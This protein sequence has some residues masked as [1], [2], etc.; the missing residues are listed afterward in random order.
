MSGIELL[1]VAASILQLADIAST[2][3]S[4]TNEL[5]DKSNSARGTIQSIQT[6]C[7]TIQSAVLSIKV[8][9]EATRNERS[10]EVV[11]HVQQLKL[12]VDLLHA[13]LAALS[14]D[15]EAIKNSLRARLRFVLSDQ[16]LKMLLEEV[17]WQSNALHLLLSALH[18][19]GP[20]QNKLKTVANSVSIRYGID[21]EDNRRRVPK[22]GSILSD[23][24]EFDFD[25][26]I[27][28]SRV[29]RDALAA[30]RQ[31]RR[32]P[33]MVPA[34]RPEYSI[35]LIPTEFCVGGPAYTFSDAASSNSALGSDSPVASTSASS[36]S[37]TATPD[38]DCLTQAILDDMFLCGYK[39][40]GQRLRS[41]VSGASSLSSRV[42]HSI[43]IRPNESWESRWRFY[44]YCAPCRWHVDLSLSVCAHCIGFNGLIRVD[45]RLCGGCCDT[46]P[47]VDGVEADGEVQKEKEM[48]EKKTRRMES[49]QK[50]L[51]DV[52]D[53]WRNHKNH[54]RSNFTSLFDGN[55]LQR[56]NILRDMPIRAAKADSDDGESDEDDDAD[57]DADGPLRL[58]DYIAHA[59]DDQ[60]VAAILVFSCAKDIGAL[61]DTDKVVKT[62]M[63]KMHVKAVQ[64]KLIY[65]LD[66]DVGKDGWVLDVFG[67]L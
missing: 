20:Q 5:K 58:D 38:E 42:A 28:N 41:T 67:R 6:E 33:A 36:S 7:S 18:L 25:D 10:P 44:I 34:K 61:L 11:L 46:Q 24:R 8:W 30:A 56:Q 2:L 14:A 37:V 63:K 62:S 22:P 13:A 19:P 40:L 64:E 49:I 54:S 55:W 26:E 39:G 45:E 21:Q 3:I 60:R 9:E 51:M 16:K 35:F 50:T 53:E 48:E 32:A 47:G 52:E 31:P 17:R 43:P 12:A 66:Y 29:Y 4:L 27:V 23:D 59:E 1:G 15:L 57:A 65:R